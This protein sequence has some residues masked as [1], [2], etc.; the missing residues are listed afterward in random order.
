M[1]IVRVLL[2]IGIGLLVVAFTPRAAH[3]QCAVPGFSDAA[4]GQNDVQFTGNGCTDS[5]NSALGSYSSTVCSPQSSCNGGVGTNGSSSGSITLTGNACAL[6]DC[7]IGYGGSTSD[8]TTTGSAACNS[9]SVEPA[10]VTLPP[11]TAPTLTA[12]SPYNVSAPPWQTLTPNESYGAVSAS[13]DGIHLVAGTYVMSSLS[14]SGGGKLIVD[15]GPITLYITGS[16]NALNLSGKGVVSALNPSD[17]TILCTDSVT[18]ASVTGNGTASFG[19]YCPKADISV[20]GNGDIYGSIVGNSVKDTGNGK[21]HYD[22][23][24]GSVTTTGI[25]CTQT[26][27][28]RATPIVAS[29]YNSACTTSPCDASVQGT[30][31]VS[32]SASEIT[33][34][35]DIASFS[36]PYIKGHL[37]AVKVSALS[38]TASLFSSAASANTLFDA[39]TGIPPVNASCSTPNGTCRYIFTNTNGSATNGL[40]ASPTVVTLS[41]A[42]TDT[43]KATTIGDA[44]VP[45][46]ALSL[47]TANFQTIITD[48]LSGSLGGVDRSTV[49]VIPAS[50][51]TTSPNRPTMVYFGA[52]DGMLHAVCAQGDASLTDANHGG[53][54]A[55]SAGPVCPAAGTELWAFLPRVELPLIR[56]NQQRLDGSPHVVDAFGNFPACSSGHKCWRTILTFQTGYAV[57]T[58]STYTPATPAAAYALDVTDPAAPTVLWEYTTPPSPS[59]TYDFGAGL[60]VTAGPIFKNNAIT[61]L[62]VLETK[63]GAVGTCALS[64]STTCYKDSDCGASNEVVSTNL[65]DTTLGT[66]TATSTNAGAA[67]TVNSDCGVDNGSANTNVCSTRPTA[68]VT[69]LDLTTGQKVWQFSPLGFSPALPYPSDTLQTG[70]PGGAVGVDLSGNGFFTD[71]LAPDLAGHLWKLAATSGANQLGGSTPMF[72]FPG[73]DTASST[74]E[75]PIGS[76]PAIFSDGTSQYAAFSSGGYADPFNGPWWH[77][78]TQYFVAVKIANT[79]VVATSTTCAACKIFR[80][81]YMSDTSAQ[82]YGWSQPL[83]V[84][85]QLFVTSDAE[86]PNF[87]GFAN[88]TVVSSSAHVSVINALSGTLAYPTPTSIFSGVSGL[89]AGVTAASD[90]SVV[91]VAASNT[92]QQTVGWTGQTATN[93][94]TNPTA[95]HAVNLSTPSKIT[96]ELWLRTE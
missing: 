10:T 84:G 11:V 6:G 1:A 61:N 51:I 91:V 16:G 18:S 50:S 38:T 19:L 64:P 5:Y 72:E 68:V 32:G 71:I 42:L 52:D 40:T 76:A 14:L 80:S 74:Q 56:S 69:A 63:N 33:T 81:L 27:V 82:E 13:G 34:A 87:T 47:T 95:G 79:E 41:D 83:I 12:A 21:I 58:A 25:S 48:I 70:V 44:I 23:A 35:T 85:D 60:T 9:E 4:F 67:C 88:G 28:S 37:R 30:F 15:S 53:S 29:L 73:A 93:A 46:S 94:G 3:A 86:D 78:G 22:Q 36:F 45:P 65:C 89:A 20:T 57:Q 24:L 92:K 17:L 39:K 7:A 26:E 96:R 66:C 77:A 59:S 75:H 54:T 55:S 62:A 90:G 43:T 31:T 49:A 8:I 2:A